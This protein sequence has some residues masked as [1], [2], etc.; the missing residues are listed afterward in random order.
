MLRFSPLFYPNNAFMNNQN[1]LPLELESTMARILFNTKRAES[2]TILIYSW[3]FLLFIISCTPKQE[4]GGAVNGALNSDFLRD[5]LY[6]QEMSRRYDQFPPNLAKKDTFYIFEMHG[7]WGMYYH[8]CAIWPDTSGIKVWKESR[9]GCDLGSKYCTNSRNKILLDTESWRGLN[10]KVQ[11]SGFWNATIQAKSSCDDCDYYRVWIKEGRHTKVLNWSSTEKI[12]DSIRILATQI[13][14]Y[15]GLPDFKPIADYFE[16]KD[17]SFI[18]IWQGTDTFF[19]KS[20]IVQYKNQ[21]FAYDG[22]L[23]IAA[24]KKGKFEPFP[25]YIYLKQTWMDGTETQN[26]ITDF[27]K[28][29]SEDYNRW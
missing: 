8:Y 12:T 13:L 10:Q 29:N 9:I 18:K 27:R 28:V 22:H 6:A 1:L 17:S 7:S 15:G 5:S 19:V 25:A 16:K 23:E 20:R 26:L 14:A 2:H 24:P 21:E 11:K 3:F 4:V